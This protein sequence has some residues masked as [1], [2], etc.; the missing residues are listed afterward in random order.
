MKW[1]KKGVIFA[2]TAAT[3][4]MTS[5]AAIPVADTT[6]DGA[7][8]IYFSSRDRAGRSHPYSIDVAADDPGRVVAV[9]DRPLFPLGPAGTFDDNGI[10]PSWIAT[11][12]ATKYLYY[13]GWN[14]QVTVSYRLAIGRAISRDGG[15]T[16]A[17]ELLGPV[18]DRSISEP[19]FCTAPCVRKEGDLWRMWYV[20]CTGWTVIR[21][22][23]EPIYC[24]KYAESPDGIAWTMGGKVCIDYDDSTQAIGRPC[25]FRLGGR[26]RM[27]Y[28]Y[29]Y[30][31]GYRTDPAKSY[32]LGYA[33]SADGIAWVRKD[34]EVGIALSDTGWDSDMIEYCHYHTHG[35][36]TY[37]FYNGNGFGQSGI[38]YAVLEQD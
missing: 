32:R 19:Y 28:S 1:I 25:V 38:G 3:E 21:E 9:C 10:M 13:I 36:N 29:R 5:H 11:D 12:G 16:Y 30:L 4:R 31:D 33:E 37:L 27:I 6:A 8:R 23:S 15:Q 24:V 34:D 14:P 7:L 17:K 20:S 35:Q 2:P 26:Y 22:R 18:C